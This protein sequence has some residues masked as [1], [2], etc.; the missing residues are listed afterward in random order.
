MFCQ[1]YYF[2]GNIFNRKQNFLGFDFLVTGY[3]FM[4][5]ALNN[6]VMNVQI[7]L[8]RYGK[9]NAVVIPVFS[10]FCRGSAYF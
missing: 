10:R 2:S 1:F 8:D 9:L 6:L 4:S 3:K 5:M 7:L